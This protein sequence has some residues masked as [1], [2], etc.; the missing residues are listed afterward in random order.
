MRVLLVEDDAGQKKTLNAMLEREGFEVSSCERVSEAADWLRRNPCDVAVLDL[1][2]RDEFGLDV[3]RKLNGDC[4]KRTRFIIHTAH[5]TFDAARD[6]LN[7]GAFAF[8][9]KLSNPSELITTVHRAAEDALKKSLSEAEEEIQFRARLLDCVQQAV[10]GTDLD[11]VIQYWNRFAE[12]TYGWT[13]AE[14]MGKNLTELLFSGAETP[15]AERIMRHVQS[16]RSWTGEFEVQHRDGHLFPVEITNSPITDRSGNLTGVVGVSSDISER[17]AAEMSLRR[18][19]ERFR[20]LAENTGAVPWNVDLTSNRFDFVGPQSERVF[21]FAQ[22]DWY[23]ENFWE[24]HIHPDDRDWVTKHCLTQA[25]ECDDFQFEYRMLDAE[26]RVRWVHDV[27]HVTRNSS[28]EATA[29]TGLLIDIT[30]YRET[31][32]SLRIVQR[33]MEAAPQGIVI[34]DARDPR[35]PIIRA[36]SA[37]GRLTGY[38]QSEVVGWNS[39]FLQGKD[40]DQP[41]AL[42][43]KAAIRDGIEETAVLRNFRKDGK[44]FLNQVSIAPVHDNEGT[45]THYIGFQQDI[46]AR[47]EVERRL[48]LT[49]FSVDK[50]RTAVMWYHDNGRLLY[51]NEIATQWLGY[52]RQEM[53]QMHFG[54]VIPEYPRE[55]WG[56]IW[57]ELRHCGEMRLD[58]RCSRRDGSE[59]PVEMFSSYVSFEGNEYQL[60]V[61]IDISDRRQLEMEREQVEFER[62]QL[63][64][65]MARIARLNSMTEMVAG[66]AHELNQ[67]IS[68]I[69]NYAAAT[70]AT[71]R[72]N[73]HP[74]LPETIKNLDQIKSIAHH[75]GQIIHRMRS[76][77][78][79]T[80][81]KELVDL[82]MM[83]ETCLEMISFSL[84]HA[85][86]QIHVEVSDEPVLVNVDP[87][88]ISQ[89]IVNLLQNA[90]DAMT[91]EGAFGKELLIRVVLEGE[92][93][94]LQLTDQGIGIPVER[95][96]RLFE[97]GPSSKPHGS[98]VG[99]AISARIV[100]THGGTISGQN[101]A[102]GGASF[103]V[104]LPAATEEP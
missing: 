20:K 74:S 63:R 11:G 70:T 91:V 75:A 87:V 25:Q 86:L 12:S 65:E 95:L 73:A 50:A 31:Q 45:L 41:E 54:D 60:T 61:M 43:L 3:L 98:G 104:Q 24:D 7:L 44:M 29:L 97:S 51:V 94:V 88:Q 67:P 10:I 53:Y 62:D 48:R 80:V 66:V 49:Q 83:V 5:G 82:K 79:I 37:F 6:A 58:T 35:M 84:R 85:G 22:E 64:D 72:N 101:N 57:E 32:E 99:L 90:I 36:N 28:E 13:V 92:M 102:D 26:G 96:K 59:F 15:D 69:A 89:V 52:T 30:E 4:P 23:Q 14:A 8:V 55:V 77:G 38:D 100:R 21:G 56:S 71:L 9:E 1:R 47:V 76:F 93:A 40:R 68:A 18:S 39:R 103:C 17:R 33:A 19:E 81:E 27:V 34:C 46:S 16:G 42:M 78:R 2:L